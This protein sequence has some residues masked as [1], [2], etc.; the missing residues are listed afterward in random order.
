MD[1]DGVAIRHF[2]FDGDLVGPRE[3]RTGLIEGDIAGGFGTE[4]RTR[5]RHLDLGAF[6]DH[7]AAVRGFSQSQDRKGA[8][9]A[10]GF[11]VDIDANA[12]SLAR[13][14]RNRAFD[15]ARGVRG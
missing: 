10:I 3:I 4:T 5:V 1:S 7:S 11:Q 9:C 14:G 2:D 15:R 13:L 6:D 8:R 12:R